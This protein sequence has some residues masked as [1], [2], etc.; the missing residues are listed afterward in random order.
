MNHPCFGRRSLLLTS[1]A[2]LAA[3]AWSQNDRAIKIVVPF[4]PGGGND[5]FAR[6]MAK[7][8][9]ELRSQSIIV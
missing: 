7:S 5:V 9:G 6:Q 8:L 4:A 1:L 2:V 3:P